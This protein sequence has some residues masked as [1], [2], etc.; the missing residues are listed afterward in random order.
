VAVQPHHEGVPYPGAF[1]LDAQG[2]VTDKRFAQSYRERETG[3]GILEQGFGGH[4]TVHGIEAHGATAGVRVRAWLDAA[5]YRFFQR[6]WLTIDLTIDPGLH[7]YGQPIPDGFIPLSVTVA[8]HDGVVV[9][10]PHWPPPQPF[11]M[12]GLDAAFVVYDGTVQLA[13]PVTF[14]QRDAGD[15]T[16]TV[17]VGYQACTTTDCLP[18][19]AVT[20]DVPV[21]AAALVS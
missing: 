9:G 5:E 10:E 11:R 1:L 6:L 15:Q 4:S 3:A 19:V 14:T 18:P 8:P 21:Y 13:L 7:L 17:T 16:L 2:V 20:L 12:D